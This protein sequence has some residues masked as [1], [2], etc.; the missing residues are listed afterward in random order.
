MHLI[1]KITCIL[2]GG[3]LTGTAMAASCYYSSATV[4]RAK[5]PVFGVDV[6]NYQGIIDWK[7]LETQNVSFAYKGY[8]RKRS[9]G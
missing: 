2:T 5:Y 9:C 1:K 4:N 7:R 6:S 3:I 8:R